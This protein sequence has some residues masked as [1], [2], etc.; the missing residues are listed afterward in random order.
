MREQE[1]EEATVAFHD[2]LADAYQAVLGAM[3]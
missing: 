2:V 1:L 3:S